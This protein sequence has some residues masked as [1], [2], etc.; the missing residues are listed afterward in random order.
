[1][2]QRGQVLGMLMHL[3]SLYC[4]LENPSISL[5]CVEVRERESD[6]VGKLI[7]ISCRIFKGIVC[8]IPRWQHQQA[9]G[10]LFQFM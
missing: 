9:S 4:A 2:V 6:V 7:N 8:A 5:L 1:M 3:K 10:N